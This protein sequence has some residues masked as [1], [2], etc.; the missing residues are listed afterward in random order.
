MITTYDDVP[1]TVVAVRA[2]GEVTAADYQKVLIPAVEQVLDQY[3]K[4]SFL[5]HLGPDFTGFTAG[6]MWDDTRVGFEHYTSWYK[7]A[8]VSD[9]SWIR[10]LAS[11]MGIFMPAQVRVFDNDQLDEA[12]RW[13]AEA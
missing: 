13:V 8:L 9:M 2:S 4:V 1:D 5:Y 6:A 12:K 3:E 10:H 11:G 7:I